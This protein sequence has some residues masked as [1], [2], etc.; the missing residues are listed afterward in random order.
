MKQLWGHDG[1]R[2]VA[3]PAIISVSPM[4]NVQLNPF[5]KARLEYNRSI[6][7]LRSLVFVV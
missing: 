3:E 4:S 1:D 7:L 2:K 6:S 5:F